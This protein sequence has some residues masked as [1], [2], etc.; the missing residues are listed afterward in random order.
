MDH[1]EAQILSSI[2]APSVIKS[3]SISIQSGFG[4]ARQGMH[5]LLEIDHGSLTDF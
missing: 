3:K 5:R 2:Y 1:G 4:S